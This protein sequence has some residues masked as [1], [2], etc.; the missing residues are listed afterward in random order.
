MENTSEDFWEM[1]LQYET[2]TIVMLDRF[3]E[4]N[5]SKEFSIKYAQ[6]YF[7]MEI[8]KTY[9]WTT[10]RVKTIQIEHIFNYFR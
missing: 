6:C 3:D 1:I 4:K 9:E 10:I 8:N 7:P 5:D 2:T